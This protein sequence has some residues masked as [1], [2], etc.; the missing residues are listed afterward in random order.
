[1]FVVPFSVLAALAAAAGFVCNPNRK[2]QWINLIAAFSILPAA[3]PWMTVNG[4]PI[5]L[6]EI[7]PSMGAGYVLLV[8][9]DLLVLFGSIVLLL[10]RKPACAS[11]TS[12][13]SLLT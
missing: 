1:M 13:G 5:P 7:L 6:S 8:L 4:V 12:A 9:G 3:F 10:S 11:I 2:I